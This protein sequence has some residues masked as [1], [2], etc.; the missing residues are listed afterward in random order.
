VLFGFSVSMNLLDV[1]VAAVRSLWFWSLVSYPGSIPRGA[2]TVI[3]SM[4]CGLAPSSLTPFRALA[5]GDGH[6]LIF[7]KYVLIDAV[8]GRRIPIPPVAPTTRVF[9]SVCG[10]FVLFG[11]I[12][13]FRLHPLRFSPLLLF[14]RVPRGDVATLILPEH[15]PLKC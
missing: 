1:A 3:L 10:F 15:V 14:F 5:K 11:A 8:C 7:T 13:V 6:L 9:L 2:K 4:R 12:Y